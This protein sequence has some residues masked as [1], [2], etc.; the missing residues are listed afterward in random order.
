M[1]FSSSFAVALLELVM[2]GLRRGKSL[3]SLIL[4]FAQQR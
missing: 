4:L 3:R 2:D 1:Q